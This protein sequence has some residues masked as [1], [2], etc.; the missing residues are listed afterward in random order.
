MVL[1]TVDDQPPGRTEQARRLADRPAGWSDLVPELNRQPSNHVV[2]KRTRGAFAST[3]LEA[4]LR[5]RGVTQVVIVGISTSGGVE[6][7]A[8]H[9]FDLGFNVTIATDA[10]TDMDAET[11]D[12]SVTCVFPKLGETATA[13]AVIALLDE[14]GA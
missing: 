5:T 12:R 14:A 8:R 7:T 10:T 11:H 9:A 2:T 4:Y 13:R 1:V 3:D 6:S